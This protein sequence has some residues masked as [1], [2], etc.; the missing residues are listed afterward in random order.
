MAGIFFFLI[1]CSFQLCYLLISCRRQGTLPSTRVEGFPSSS[2]LTVPRLRLGRL[3][4]SQ[5]RDSSNTT[6][7]ST[8]TFPSS[9]RADLD[10][11]KKTRLGEVRSVTQRWPGLSERAL[12]GQS[13]TET[14]RDNGG[15]HSWGFV[16]VG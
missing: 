3:R 14:K 2:G 15:R 10:E 8:S 11:R 12:D 9:M 16:L 6:C 13:V 4:L 1:S 7:S 5:A